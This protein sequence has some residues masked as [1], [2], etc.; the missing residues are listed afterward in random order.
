[1]DDGVAVRRDAEPVIWPERIGKASPKFSR[2]KS[3]PGPGLLEDDARLEA[4]RR[5]EVITLIRCV[6]IELKGYPHVGR[7]PELR[8]LEPAIDHA[9]DD[10][11][12]AAEGYRFPENL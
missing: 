7:R 1:L 9:D 8:D 2:R 5:A 4:S 6:G 12:F 11:R 3:Q 10:V